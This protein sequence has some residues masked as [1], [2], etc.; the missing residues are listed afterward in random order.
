MQIAAL[1]YVAGICAAGKK[2]D[3]VAASSKRSSLRG[4]FMPPKQFSQE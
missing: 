4:G 1:Q 2:Y 3:E